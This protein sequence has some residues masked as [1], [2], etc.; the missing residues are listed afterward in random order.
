M[1]LVAKY[2]MK[3]SIFGRVAKAIKDS[4]VKPIS[5]LIMT[6]HHVHLPQTSIIPH[7]FNIRVE[8]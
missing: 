7:R 2:L 1:Q 5:A 3:V 6:W 8:I 4:F